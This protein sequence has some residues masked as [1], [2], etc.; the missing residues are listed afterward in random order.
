MLSFKKNRKK[1][2]TLVEMIFYIAVFSAVSLILIRAVLIMVASFRETQVVADINQ[3]NQIMER[4][5]REIRQA[6]SIQTISSTNLKLNTTD[7]AG[8]PATIT[9]TLS[10]TNLELRENDVLVGNLN[11]STISVTA[12]SFIQ[13]VMIHSTGVKVTMTIQSSRYGVVKTENFYNTL[14]LRGSY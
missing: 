11:P 10:G 2:F 8:N 14:V 12:L 9:F 4:I 1:G 7:T 3:T 13:Q 6:D 5:S